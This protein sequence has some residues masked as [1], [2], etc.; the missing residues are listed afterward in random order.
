MTMRARAIGERLKKIGDIFDEESTKMLS[1]LNVGPISSR[2]LSYACIISLLSILS[3]FCAESE[4]QQFCKAWGE[5]GDNL[6]P[7]IRRVSGNY[8]SL[9]SIVYAKRTSLIIK[10]LLMP[11]NTHVHACK[12]KPK[13]NYSYK[14]IIIVSVF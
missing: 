11:Y 2:S 1:T 6:V 9:I 10:C 13:C 12:Q 7:Q 8:C 14:L 5:L 4:Y 3:D